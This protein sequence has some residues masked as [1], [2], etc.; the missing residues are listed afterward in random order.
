MNALM[1]DFMQRW[2]WL[3][4][5]QFLLVAGAWTQHAAV[6]QSRIHLE[7]G[8][9]IAMSWDLMRGVVRVQ[10]GVP[11]SRATVASGLWVSVVVLGA[12]IQ[13][14]AML[15]GGV[16][17]A[18]VFGKGVNFDALGLHAV[19][20]VLMIG[21]S[22]FLLTGLPAAPPRNMAEQ[23][24]CGFFGLMWGLSMWGFFA[25]T[26]VAPHQ[27]SAVTGIHAF[28]MV[29]MGVCAVASWFTTWRMLM[30]RAVPVQ[31]AAGFKTTGK[32]GLMP[33]G[34]DGWPV[35]LVQEGR[36]LLPVV[37]MVML[38]A[39]FMVSIQQ[40]V[41]GP[42]EIQPDPFQYRS[43]GMLCAM[44]TF[45]MIMVTMGTLR[46]GRSL[47]VARRSWALVMTLRPFVGGVLVFVVF[48]LVSWVTGR[49]S[50]IEGKALMTF[51]PWCSALSLVQALVLRF[52]KMVVVIGL[53]MVIS[54][55][56]TLFPEM[57]QRRGA[58]GA[59]L[60]AGLAAGLLVISAWLH[61]RELTR[62]DALYRVNQGFLRMIGGAQ[63]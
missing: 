56:G 63:R 19:L 12:G 18:P 26:F 37:L 33:M 1:L 62:S 9:A 47:P 50:G 53:I 49:S 48:S 60:M 14:L 34:R 32:P 10:L 21:T 43:M 25:L 7:I 58:D 44:T 2:K 11:Q 40:P 22:Q 59:G 31:Q 13:W 51:L 38:A 6:P 55:F 15:V 17:L 3:L 28:V 41:G 35:W 30:E 16:I 23:I 24:K 39:V 45:P 36:W 27:W 5:G 61:G 52:P 4:V 54:F 42:L 8:L 57:L 20:S 46:A 29:V